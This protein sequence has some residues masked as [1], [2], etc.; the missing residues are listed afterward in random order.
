MPLA[1]RQRNAEGMRGLGAKR[2][3]YAGSDPF[4]LFSVRK[5]FKSGGTSAPSP[6]DPTALANAQTQSNIT[7]ANTQAALNNVNTVSPLGSTLFSP[8]GQGGYNLNQTLSPA[9]QSVFGPQVNLAGNLA[10]QGQWIADQAGQTA[11]SGSAVTDSAINNIG[12]AATSTPAPPLQTSLSF[13]A[14]PTPIAPAG[15][16]GQINTSGVPNIPTAQ[17]PFSYQTQLN[18]S[19]VPGLPNSTLT[20]LDPSIAQAQNAA[21]NTQ[22][23]YL[24]PQQAEQ[25]AQLTQQLADQG[26]QPGTQAYTQATGDVARQ[27]TFANQ[28]AQNAAVAAGNQQE[29]SLFGQQLAG[30]GQG[31]GQALAGG[32]F[33]NTATQAQNAALQAL[34]GEQLAGQ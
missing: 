14:L 19:G 6:I 4:S 29:Q 31:F 33:T 15:Y 17:N 21:Y 34:F 8:N 32:Q 10:N 22:E 13:G 2:T 23:A 25:S 7:T 20:G 3:R 9:L 24:Q 12:T 30:Q 18:T 1:P 27:Q 5:R 16:Q 11:A 26:I 28:Q